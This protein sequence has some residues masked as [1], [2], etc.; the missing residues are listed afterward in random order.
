MIQLSDLTKSFGDRVLFDH[1][2]WQISCESASDYAG[3][4]APARRPFCACWPG[5]TNRTVETS[6]NLQ[7]PTGYLPQDGILHSGRSVFDE[8]C[9]AF[10][11]LLALKEKC[12][13][14]KLDSGT[15]VPAEEH[16]ACSA[17]TATSRTAF[18]WATDT[19]SS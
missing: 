1:V 4:T 12:T 15:S 13:T 2:T 8:A 14:S 5:S 7:P 3:R 10:A 19:T 16:D 18:A 9:L 6:S 17:V 11:P